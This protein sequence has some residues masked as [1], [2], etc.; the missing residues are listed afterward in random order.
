M[1]FPLCVVKIAGG[2]LEVAAMETLSALPVED[3]V[4]VALAVIPREGIRFT[5]AGEKRIPVSVD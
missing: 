1:A 5:Q 4:A 2:D 3:K